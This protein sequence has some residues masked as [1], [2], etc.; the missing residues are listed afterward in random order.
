ME[1]TADYA[2][3]IKERPPVLAACRR[4]VIPIKDIGSLIQELYGQLASA[5][6][7]PAGPLVTIHHEP[8]FNPEGS[9]LEICIPVNR[10][11]TTASV[12]TR[13][14]PGGSSAC[15]IHLGSY[16]GI[17]AAYAALMRWVPENGYAFNGPPVETYLV[18]PEQA[19]DEARYV[20]EVSLPVV[21]Q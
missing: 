1:L 4:Q 5:G 17:G 2:I 8:D 14:I 10:Q 20:T 12:S 13:E 6:L 18:G 16:S 15:T 7:R 9:D 11:S 19:K 3:E 21:K